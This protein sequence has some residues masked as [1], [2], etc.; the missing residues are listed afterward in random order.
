MLAGMV[1]ATLL[2]FKLKRTEQKLVDSNISLHLAQDSLEQ[3]K[4]YLV[5][6]ERKN[7]LLK[8]SLKV[9]LDLIRDRYEAEESDPIFDRKDR[10][11]EKL[12]NVDYYVGVYTLSRNESNL[13]D[14][15]SYLTQEGYTL[16]AG[17][18]LDNRPSWLALNS[19]VFY[20]DS[21]SKKRAE[22]FAREMK[23]LTQ[24][25]FNVQIGSGLGV[26][27]DQ[28]DFYFYIHVIDQ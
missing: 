2:F 11:L 13:R 20:Y 25:S 24:K 4:A 6:Q 9:V 27:S 19:T 5:E 1:I 8:D 26:P 22:Q 17:T 28:K 21:S 23:R 15:T 14:I 16:V 7:T 12:T 18:N 3:E 10:L